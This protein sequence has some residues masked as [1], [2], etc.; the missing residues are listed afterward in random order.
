MEWNDRG[1]KIIFPG[2]LLKIKYIVETIDKSQINKLFVAK[3]FSKL[4]A[5][6]CRM[7]S[8]CSLQKQILSLS[9]KKTFFFCRDCFPGRM[10]HP[11]PTAI[12]ALL[13][14]AGQG[15]IGNVFITSVTRYQMF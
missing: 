4:P 7:V 15:Q 6:K 3:K 11:R 2:Y 13:G 5:I 9:Y 1:G 8:A 14:T 10:G 12:Y